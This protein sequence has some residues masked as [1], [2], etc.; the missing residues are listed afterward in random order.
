MPGLFVQKFKQ[1]LH[2]VKWIK[3]DFPP[4]NMID[5]SVLMALTQSN[6]MGY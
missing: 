6:V 4:K 5:L 1:S 3:W 2:D